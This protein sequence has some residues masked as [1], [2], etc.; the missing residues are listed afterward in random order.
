VARA[1]RASS[2]MLT[3]HKVTGSMNHAARA[4]TTTSVRR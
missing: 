2:T 1:P 3:A 4:A